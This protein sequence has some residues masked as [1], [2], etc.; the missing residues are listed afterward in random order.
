MASE[1]PQKHAAVFARWHAVPSK[2]SVAETAPGITRR[3]RLKNFASAASTVGALQ[4]KTAVDWAM[5]H[6][7]VAPVHTQS[8]SDKLCTT[9]VEARVW[10]AQV[11]D[12][13]CMQCFHDC[14]QRGGIGRLLASKCSSCGN[15]CIVF[16]M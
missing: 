6:D 11:M 14:F 2:F 1:M 10:V 3:P 9:S 5:A 7:D 16:T 8:C 13:H 15:F 4:R 12:L